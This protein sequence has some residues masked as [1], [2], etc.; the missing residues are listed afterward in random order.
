MTDKKQNRGRPLTLTAIQERNHDG[1]HHFTAASHPMQ[2][3]RRL[4]SPAKQERHCRLALVQ[5]RH[6]LPR[7]IVEWREKFTKRLHCLRT[8]ST[9]HR[10]PTT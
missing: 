5:E 4:P 9:R 1:I 3:R 10:G 6:P 8:P 7:A 2:Q